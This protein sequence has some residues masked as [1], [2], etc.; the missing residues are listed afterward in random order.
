MG[1]HASDWIDVTSGVPQGS[2]LGPL[3]FILFINDLPQKINNLSKIYADDNKILAISNKK[4]L[5]LDI[6]NTVTWT[7]ENQVLL[8]G[9][10]CKILH[11]GSNNNRHIYQIET[12]GIRYPIPSGTEEKDVGIF[13]S[14]DLK[15]SNHIDRTVS[16]AYRTLGLLI[17]TFSFMDSDTFKILYCSFVRPLLEFAAPVWNPYLQKDIDKLERVQRKATKLAPGLRHLDY[18]AR[19]TALGITSFLNVEKEVILFRYLKSS[20]VLT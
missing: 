6:N 19:L 9:D 13:F 18:E 11:F 16:R 2:V 3:L 4:K 15:F 1:N 8:N 17:N 7:E 14:S 20:K 10:K 12:K 5:Q